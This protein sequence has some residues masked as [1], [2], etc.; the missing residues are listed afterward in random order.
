MKFDGYG[1]RDALA[2]VEPCELVTAVAELVDRAQ[3]STAKGK[4]DVAHEVA[5]QAMLAAICAERKIVMLRER[6]RRLERLATTDELTGV[7]NRRGFE[8]ELQRTLDLARRHGETGVL[9]FIDLDD[10]K[11][12]NDTYGHAAGD[13][14]LRYVASLLKKSVRRSDVVARLGGDEFVVLLTK[15]CPVGGKNR[16]IALERILRSAVLHW[17]DRL[18][19]IG[20]S[21]GAHPYG[22]FDEYDALIKEADQHMYAQK[23]SRTIRGQRSKAE[24]IRR[25][26]DI[27]P[28][29]LTGSMAL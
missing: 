13:E 2:R 29:L 19:K 14:V 27:S 10:F 12:V 28:E 3:Y 21:V 22:P 26:E 15:A 8:A 25:R 1:H 7:L 6:I 24:D 4:A 23:P 11:R 20:A 17:H 5:Q 9:L 16:R 18:I